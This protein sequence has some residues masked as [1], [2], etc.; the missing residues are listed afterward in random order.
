MIDWRRNRWSVLTVFVGA[1]AGCIVVQ[2]IDTEIL[3]LIV[4]VLL[5]LVAAYVLLSP[6][7]G[8]SDA[9]HRLGSNGY[10]PIASLDTAR[11]D[12]N[13]RPFVIAQA[14]KMGS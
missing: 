7:M 8:D 12:V 3:A 14:Q 5:V 10:A 1:G 4:P 13:R 11:A 9:Q 2:T 6:R